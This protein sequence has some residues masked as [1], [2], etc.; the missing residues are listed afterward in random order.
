[1]TY[2]ELYRRGRERLEAA[3]VEEA[4]LDARLLLEHVCGT[5]RN[6]LLVRGDEPVAEEKKRR[7]LELLAGREGRIPLQRLTGAQ[8]FMGLDFLVNGHV[9][10][11]RQDTEILVEEALKNL[12]DGMEILDLCTGSG[13]IL[14]SL[15]RYTNGCRGLGTDI[16]PQALAVARE[17]AERLIPEC[18]LQKDG[19][20]G[21]LRFAE[22][23]LYE[24]VEGKF[25]VIVS[26][27]P[28]IPTGAIETLMPEV[29]DHEPRQALDGGRDGLLFYRRILAG[30]GEH[31]KGGGM[32]F[33]E[34]GHDQGKAVAEMMEQ[35]GFLEVRLAKDYAGLDRVASGIRRMQLAE[36]VE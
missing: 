2:R 35:A 7:Y 30:A 19:G 14:I 11:P 9:L 4:G 24:H 22:S 27:P 3:G 25:D 36:A 15:L 16:S 18:L 5:D 23:D 28:Y 10:I 17:N 13:C 31:L 21:R 8:N 6:A 1:M 20:G 12:H 33:L 29:R 26:N 32:L 34:V